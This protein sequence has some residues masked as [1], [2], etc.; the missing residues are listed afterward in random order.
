MSVENLALIVLLNLSEWW[1]DNEGRTLVRLKNAAATLVLVVLNLNST[2]KFHF[3]FFLAISDYWPF[4]HFFILGFLVI[5]AQ[6]SGK[7]L[8]VVSFWYLKKLFT[9]IVNWIYWCNWDYFKFHIKFQLIK[10]F[11]NK[12]FIIKWY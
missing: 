10:N 4:C 5:S 8:Q 9:D 12:I 1:L 2:K 3:D 6:W 11:K 7:L